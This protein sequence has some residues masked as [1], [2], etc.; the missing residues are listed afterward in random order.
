MNKFLEAEIELF[1][2][3]SDRPLVKSGAPA[4]FLKSIDRIDLFEEPTSFLSE[5]YVDRG[6]TP[7]RHTWAKA[8]YSLKSWFQYLQ[9]NDTDWITASEQHR[10]SYRNDFLQAISRNTGEKYGPAGIRDSMTVIRKF[11]HFCALRRIYYGDIGNSAELEKEKNAPIDRD[12]VAETRGSGRLV[13]KDYALPKARPGVKI[14]PMMVRDLQSLLN[15][16]GPQ[17]GDRDGDQRLA[18]DRLICDLG[19]V[20]GLRLSEMNQL[21]TLQFLSLSPDP[22]TPLNNMLL[23]I[24]RGKGGV[25]RQVAIPTW[26]VMDALTYIRGERGEALKARKHATKAEPTN[27]LLAHARSKSA[28]E[29]ITNGAIQKMFREACLALG[30]V[31]IHEKKDPLTGESYHSKSPKHS[32][33]DLRHT[34]AVLTYHAERAIGNAEPWKKI[35]AQLGHRHLHTTIDTYLAHVEIFSDQPGLLDVRKLLGI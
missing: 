15:H 10:R 23:L 1:I 25:A 6:A 17:A 31:T 29:P 27:L 30:I 3:E 28:G 2:N 9:A 34:Y 7:S 5:H 18:R 21:T 22:M 20:I 19:W 13:E 32:V 24:R 12:A 11:H 14:H 26:L 33:H 4:F 8:A 35:Q 16:V